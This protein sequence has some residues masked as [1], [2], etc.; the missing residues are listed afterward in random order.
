[1]FR[2]PEPRRQLQAYLRALLQPG[3]WKTGGALAR[4][5]RDVQPDAMQRLLYHAQWD[6][7]QARAILRTWLR[8]H[9]GTAQAILVLGEGFWRKKGAHSVGV[10]WHTPPGQPTRLY[11]Q[12]ALVLSMVTRHQA[13][14]LDLRLWVAPAWW[15]DP[16]R[17]RARIPADLPWQDTPDLALAMLQQAWPQGLSLAPVV[18]GLSYGC[19][20]PL[21]TAITAQGGRFLLEIPPDTVVWP[22]ETLAWRPMPVHAALSEVV[23]QGRATW[24]PATGARVPP[25]EQGTVWAM[26]YGTLADA[27][28]GAPSREDVWLIAQ[29]PS[30]YTPGTTYYLASGSQPT[31]HTLCRLTAAREAAAQRLSVARHTVGLGHAEVRHWQSWYRHTTLALMADAWRSVTQ[32]PVRLAR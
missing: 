22:H 5:A 28:T 3:T 24:R 23:Q 6:A 1:V 32:R 19:A 29:R 25:T 18:G 16:L 7:A 30:A 9:W 8:Q 21:R 26:T 14:L 27:Q 10:G 20:A 15:T 2:R 13:V 17:Q 4:L 11:G 12:R 31:I